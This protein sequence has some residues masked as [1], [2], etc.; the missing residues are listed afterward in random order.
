[1]PHYQVLVA[2]SDADSLYVAQV[3]DLPGC[4]AHG[5][6][7][8]EALESARDAIQLYLEDIQECGEP[9]PEVREYHLLTA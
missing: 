1:M 8:A 2:W 6:S 9:L 4:L 3:P 5:D 7:A